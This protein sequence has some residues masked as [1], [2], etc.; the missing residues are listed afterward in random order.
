M[1]RILPLLFVTAAAVVAQEGPT[2]EFALPDVAGSLRRLDAG[3]WG[4]VWR[5]PEVEAYVA[6]ARVA[7][8][9]TSGQQKHFSLFEA[10]WR[11]WPWTEFRAARRGGDP[12]LRMAL[13]VGPERAAPLVA[14]L[15]A[16]RPF[17][18]DLVHD[19]GDGWIV[20]GPP[21][22]PPSAPAAS[23]HHDVWW[24]CDLG[25]ALDPGS[26]PGRICALLGFQGFR[27]TIDADA[28]GLHERL[29]LPGTRLPFG[30]IEPAIVDSLPGK[31]LAALAVAIDGMRLAGLAEALLVDPTMGPTL[32]AAERRLA[33]L[34]APPLDTLLRA[35]TGTWLVALERLE[36]QPALALR[37]PAHPAFAALL[38]RLVP[39][40]VGPD[41]AATLLPAPAP[42]LPALWLRRG[43]RGCALATDRAT[44][45][46][47]ASG[48]GG[49][50]PLSAASVGQPAAL[51]V[52]DL[53]GG[54]RSL[55][56]L[57]PLLRRPAQGPADHLGPLIAAVNAAAP[58]LPAAHLALHRDEVGLALEGRNGLVL[59]Y[60]L[61]LGG[62]ARTP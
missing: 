9:A 6:Q 28:G 37:F 35:A 41:A 32:A 5:L 48:A 20:I 36:P 11:T 51:L 39:G 21:G 31:P 46:L 59:V 34:G 44:A 57:L 18:N 4:A 52:G 23:A 19:G 45:E 33:A 50:F 42:P 53:T 62:L 12:E 58:A 7:L 27:L 26:A 38:E 49:G 25:S 13:C 3:P 10:Q 29:A 14:E 24:E 17:V 40:S 61:I 47:L 60:T 15:R 1:R 8:A 55:A 16:G 22:P 54:A 56:G 2:Q 30:I 43:E